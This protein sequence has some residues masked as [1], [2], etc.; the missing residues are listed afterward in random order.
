MA[1]C[2]NCTDEAI[3]L[4]ETKGAQTQ[5]FCDKDLPWFLRKAATEGSLPRVDTKKSE[6]KKEEV[7]PVSKLETSEN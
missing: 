2:L 7:K 5:V 3:W 1:K 4:V 6:V